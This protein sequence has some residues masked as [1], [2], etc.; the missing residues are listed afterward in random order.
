MISSQNIENSVKPQ[1]K[2]SRNHSTSN[3]GELSQSQKFQKV[4][5]KP[6]MELRKP[7]LQKQRIKRLQ[8]FKWKSHPDWL[9]YRYY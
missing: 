2:S 8:A 4:I 7:I 6:E 1:G 9:Q 3:I 5:I